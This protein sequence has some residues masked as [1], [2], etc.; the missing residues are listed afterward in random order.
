M[1]DYSSHW[2][3]LVKDLR[4]L[5][6]ISIDSYC[7]R[8][9]NKARAS[10]RAK[11][12]SKYL[13]RRDRYPPDDVHADEETLDGLNIFTLIGRLTDASMAKAVSNVDDKQDTLGL[14]KFINPT[15]AERT[16]LQ[17]ATNLFSFCLAEHIN[18]NEHS[19]IHRSLHDLGALQGFAKYV[20]KK[21]K[22]P[23]FIRE[24]IVHDKDV[25]NHFFSVCVL[26]ICD[27][28]E[29]RTSEPDIWGAEPLP[30]YDDK[31]KE[32]PSFSIVKEWERYMWENGGKTDEKEMDK[33]VEFCGKV[34]SGVFCPPTTTGRLE[35]QPAWDVID[36]LHKHIIE[37]SSP[38]ETNDLYVQHV[39][40]SIERQKHHKDTINAWKSYCVQM[41]KSWQLN[42]ASEWQN[43][44]SS[45]LAQHDQGLI[46]WIRDGWGFEF[47]RVDASERIFTKLPS[48]AHPEAN[49]MGVV[50]GTQISLATGGSVAVEQLSPEA[51]ILTHRESK[52]QSNVDISASTV[53]L[54][55]VGFNGEKPFA[56]D[57]QV[58]HTSTGLRAVN[59]DVARRLN[60]LAKIGKL[61]VGH[62]LY[63]RKKGPPNGIT[64]YE[65]QEIKSIEIAPSDSQPV[66][67][68]L[69]SNLPSYHANGYLV[70]TNNVEIDLATAAESLKQIPASQLMI[71]LSSI[72]ELAN[73]F[74]Q[75]DIRTIHERVTGEL[76]GSKRLPANGNDTF[77]N[78]QFVSPDE[79][80]KAIY[81]SAWARS[82]G[83]S[84]ECLDLRLELRSSKQIGSHSLPA[85][86]IVDGILVLDE[87]PQ[88]SAVFDQGRRTFRWSRKLPEGGKWG[89]EHG[90][91]RIYPDGTGGCGAIQLS[92]S[93]DAVDISPN[94]LVPFHAVPPSAAANKTKDGESHPYASGNSLIIEPQFYAKLKYD[95]SKWPKDA[96]K[97]TSPDL[98]DGDKVEIAIYYSEQKGTELTLSV[99]VLD[100]LQ[101][102]INQKFG[103]NLSTFYSTTITSTK[104]GFQANIEVDN[105]SIMP[106][107]SSAGA[108]ISSNFNLDFK[109]T[110][111]I[112]SKL[113]LLFQSMQIDFDMDE[114]EA[115]GA[116]F[117]YNP[118]MRGLNGDRHFL[119]G[120]M[121]ISNELGAPSTAEMRSTISKSFAKAYPSPGVSQNERVIGQPAPITKDLDAYT[122]RTVDG[123]KKIDYKD[124]NVHNA[125]QSIL[126]NTLYYHMTDKQRD[127]LKVTKPK[128]PTDLADGLPQKIQDFLQKEYAPAFIGQMTSTVKDY[129]KELEEPEKEK[130]WYWFQGQGDKCMSKRQE[131]SD[132]NNL[133]AIEAV[134]QIHER[135]LAPYMG[136]V[137]DAKMWAKKLYDD[138]IDEWNV[139]L[140]AMKCADNGGYIQ[141]NKICMLLNVLDPEVNFAEE[142][143][144]KVIPVVRHKHLT[145]P[146]IGPDEAPNKQFIEDAMRNLILAVFRGDKD[147][148]P[149][150][151]AGLLKDL[152]D[153]EKANN[154]QV[155]S[156]MTQRANNIMTKMAVFNAEI[157]KW[158]S[159]IAQVVKKAFN[160]TR[161]FT[162]M[163]QA[164]EKVASKVT[165]IVN[166]RLMKGIGVL[167]MGAFYLFQI[168]YSVLNLYQ[169]WDKL[170]DDQRAT[171]M[172]ETIRVLCDAAGKA[173]GAWDR[174]KKTGEPTKPQDFLDSTELD[175]QTGKNLGSQAKGLDEMGEKVYGKKGLRKIVS[176]GMAEKAPT[177]KMKKVLRWNESRES[178]PEGLPGDGAKVAKKFSIQGNFLRILN[179]AIGIGVT[180]CMTF[181]LIRNWDD[182][183]T[184]GKILETAT[185]IIQ[186]LTVVIDII[187]VGSAVGLFAVTG[188]LAV[189]LPII[190]AVLAVLGIIVMIL[191][192]FLN[193]QAQHTPPDPVKVYIKNEVKSLVKNWVDAPKNR[194][195]YDV[196]P[197]SIG[198]GKQSALNINVTNKTSSE[199]TLHNSSVTITSGTDEVCLFKEQ[200][201]ELVK[202][203]DPKKDAPG[204]V[205]LNAATVGGSLSKTDLGT[206]SEYHKYTL[207]IFGPEKKEEK[208]FENLVLKPN[209][210]FT[211]KWSGTVNKAGY[212]L[213]DIV[214]RWVKDNAHS[215]V[216]ITRT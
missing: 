49:G 2:K 128:L 202:S 95:K 158:L 168:G 126:L 33:I 181:S 113:P 176:E 212:C 91:L 116:V 185:L 29:K 13:G 189:A 144:E 183:T 117:E 1:P 83:I 35:P 55:L 85:V 61:K 193:T 125:S 199:V 104:D 146:W 182:L 170:R 21:A 46:Q 160:G 78:S 99:P 81:T 214:E 69:G 102:D 98:I 174:Y 71:F 108:D 157:S 162:W 135:D 12:L 79:R 209:Q 155:V 159:S 152:E 47:D 173:K 129:E 19:S 39:K 164:F 28:L 51:P 106:F 131:Y 67:N 88:H 165:G 96:P 50:A 62:V 175:Q 17:L 22:D 143:F 145:Y 140:Y 114:R 72:P 127:I 163:G 26:F 207:D 105:A 177:S 74:R 63:R 141:I 195:T 206:T 112:D 54:S 208:S 138:M 43:A 5:G 80:N 169:N 119:K 107:I 36:G 134:K 11:H 48:F 111:G 147:I 10:R 186:F 92:S 59:P 184:V 118:L 25:S 216:P 68:V 109:S 40:D 166:A 90:S 139:S 75:Y 192:F 123:L 133:T 34:S 66:Y 188:T 23:F 94:S 187:E 156:D 200:T 42:I 154:I 136:T 56:S 8:L 45:G 89:F 180:V 14:K 100:K 31:Y 82:S 32:S 24:Q 203:T 194:L 115:T 38:S 64:A 149:A 60:P 7:D 171:I 196:Q 30:A 205:Y 52:D 124:Q 18:F 142:W 101:N 93:M 6:S 70:N 148:T 53:G 178:I 121:G 120:R 137:T 150:I 37:S 130:I 87:H 103:S 161:M 84:I 122:D 58:F 3:A 4:V 65:Y 210:T 201:I 77:T 20:H 97:P 110:L 211:A 197:Q 132:L 86:R 213:V 27:Y 179:A 151:R 16:D 204:H 215:Q 44:T 15:N 172:M 191:G 57:A 9:Y 76:Y 73:V 198:S 167:A 190:G 41:Q 153:F